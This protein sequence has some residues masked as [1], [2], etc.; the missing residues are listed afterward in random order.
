MKIILR[1][2]YITYIHSGVTCPIIAFENMSPL[3]GQSLAEVSGYGSFRPLAAGTILSMV[4]EELHD[5]KHSLR[6]GA[7]HIHL[8]AH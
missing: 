3:R 6:P 5:K 8:L 2:F 4:V 1:Q 7:G